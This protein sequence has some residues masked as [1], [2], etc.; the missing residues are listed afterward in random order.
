MDKHLHIVTHDVPWPA[1]YGG[2]VDLFYKIVSLHSLGCKINLHCFTS[3]RKK[4]DVLNNY[5]E[6][7]HYYKRK[8]ISAFSFSIPYIVQSRNNKELISRLQK[9]NHPVLL[10]GIHCTYF[11][12]SGE[13]CNR[14]IFLRLHN[15]EFEYY[16][17]L[18]LYEKNVFRSFFFRR[19][20]R[21]LKKYEARIANMA[22]IWT[23]SIH[24]TQLYKKEFKAND[25]HFLPVFLPWQKVISQIGYGNFCLYH[26]NLSINENEKAVIWLL[27]NIFDTLDMPFVI[28]GKDPGRFLKMKAHATP[29]TCLVGNPNE[30]EMQDLIGKAQVNILPSFNNTGVKLKLLNALFNGRHCI[31]NASAIEGSGT[32]NLC[33]IASTPADFK[34]LLKEL[35]IEPFTTQQAILRQQTL[36]SLY[37]NEKNALRIM[38]WIY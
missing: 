11:L 16:Y 19:E 20:S 36:Q 34:I 31:V 12:H 17:H 28:A 30:N 3:G 29:N 14:K 1:D 32:N 5:C 7:V 35:F 9:D 13:L 22:P 25:I 38:S 27:E 18:A 21:L 8:R 6:A 10:E 4:H 26:G 23:V 33:R 2:V 37:D 24:D 15:V